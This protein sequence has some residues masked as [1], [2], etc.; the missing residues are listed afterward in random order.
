[1]RSNANVGAQGPT[2]RFFVQPR[3][4]IKVSQALEKGN[5]K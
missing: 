2:A 5:F 1:M 4:D 3:I